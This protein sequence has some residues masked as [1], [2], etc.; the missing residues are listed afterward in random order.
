MQLRTRGLTVTAAKNNRFPLLKRIV[1]L[2]ANGAT[3][4]QY[5]L[6]IGAYCLK[7][8]AGFKVGQV[9]KEKQFKPG[10]WRVSVITGLFYDFNQ[11]SVNHTCEKRII[12]RD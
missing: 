7:K 9:V 5:L 11:N 1:S 2:M 8:G 3:K 12:K 4:Q 10:M 6:E